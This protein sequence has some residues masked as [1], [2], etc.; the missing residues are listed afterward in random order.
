MADCEK[1][2][3]TSYKR[4]LNHVRRLLGLLDSLYG[5]LNGN[6]VV[7]CVIIV[8]EEGGITYFKVGRES[9]NLIIS[10]ESADVHCFHAMVADF[11]FCVAHINKGTIDLCETCSLFYSRTQGRCRETRSFGSTSMRLHKGDIIGISAESRDECVVHLSLVC[12]RSIDIFRPSFCYL[13]GITF[14]MRLCVV[15]CIRTTLFCNYC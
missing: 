15:K 10:D 2:I 12:M 7:T 9:M 14:C 4:L 1:I 8:A 6:A 13:V 5:T 11:G 3:S